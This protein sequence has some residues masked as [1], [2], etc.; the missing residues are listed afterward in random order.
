MLN[1]EKFRPISGE[2]WSKH[3]SFENVPEKGVYT[4]SIDRWKEQYISG[5]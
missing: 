4:Q 3:S 5:A 2:K 1:T